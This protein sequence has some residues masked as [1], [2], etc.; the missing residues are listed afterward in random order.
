[1]DYSPKFTLNK[2]DLKKIG[3]GA[4]MALGGSAV[5]YGLSVYGNVDYGRYTYIIIP[6]LSIL[7]N[8]ARKWL[9]E[10]DN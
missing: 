6:V 8:A 9:S 3:V 4:L 5:G 1:M 7:L 2:A 10:N